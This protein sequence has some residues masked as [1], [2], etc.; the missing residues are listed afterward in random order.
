[1]TVFP[2]PDPGK[3]RAS[4]SRFL[5]IPTTR[6]IAPASEEESLKSVWRTLRK[7]KWWIS[8]WV[9]CGIGLAIVAC[10]VIPDQ[11][12]STATVQVGKDQTVQVDLSDN[13][14]P[15]LSESDTK[16]DIAT[17]MA[18]IKDNDT[19]LAVIKDL[20]LENHKPFKY[21]PSLM[22]WI[23]GGNRRIE[24]EKNLPL[25]QAPARRDRLLRMF[26][27]KLVVKNPADTRL[28]T[29]GF[30]NP[31]PNLSAK[32][33]NDV[34][35][36]YVK[37]ESEGQA[38]GVGI[39]LLSQE[40]SGLK[41][42]ME[43]DQK[44]LADYE[45]QTGLNHLLLRSI[46]EGNGGG[47]ITHIPA[48][49]KLDTLNQELTVAEANRIGKEAIYDLTKTHNSDVVAGLAHSSIPAIATSAVVTQGN[50]LNLLETL[51]QEQGR[52]RLEYSA[53][54]TK[55]GAKN[56]QMIELESQLSNV[57]KQISDELEQIDLRARNDYLV[58]LRNERGLQSEFQN[59]QKIAGQLN[60]SAVTLQML[61]QQ[62][63]SSRKLYDSLYQQIQ[64]A[65]IQAGL[66]A[67]NLRVTDVARPHPTPS[68]PNP[69]LYLAVGL[70]AGFL[71]GVSSAFVREH[72]DETVKTH[73]QVD[74]LTPLPV[75]ASIPKISGQ[76]QKALHSG[77]SI[78]AGGGGS[79]TSPLVTRPRSAAAEA[80]RALRTSIVLANAGLPL[81][82]LVVTSPLIG[83]GKTSVSYNLAV[84]F[85]QA[86][87][88]VLLI[89]AD[90]HH[91]RLHDYFGSSQTPGVGDVLSGTKTLESAIRAHP[92]IG[93]LSLLPAGN[94]PAL[95]G[96]LLASSKFDVMFQGL[97]Q[98]YSMI[99]MDTPPMLLVA[100]A[101]L[102]AGKAD[103]SLAVLRSDMTNR[104]AV[105]RMTETLERNGCRSIGLVLN[106]VD[107][108]SIDYYHAYGHRGGDRY[109]K[110]N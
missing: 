101:L 70:A 2:P 68:K 19:A 15:T 22:G 94:L 23:T 84:A 5:P 39:A 30:L 18:I 8:F 95:P 66:R 17:H 85:A 99:I 32:I 79:E 86:G 105:E 51:R 97:K 53:D 73:L 36:E 13:S 82:S 47:N 63:T 98:S 26:S 38:G 1:M 44:Q 93:N 25:S 107:T 78:V 96:E 55:Y 24:A 80:Y 48:L 88:R 103:A 12:Q 3:G 83:E 100:D 7:R 41:T 75:L 109:F 91:P 61:V 74:S 60:Q 59:Q 43:G 52:L 69:P 28:I 31:D 67:T 58:A 42:K 76:R 89:D 62:A 64:E 4:Q 27:K 21:H 20:N 11:Y 54:V 34:V 46:G 108:S 87:E 56:P 106:G 29:V 104:T 102:L 110:E 49:D 14:E 71:F 72:M 16:T 50:G 81:R 6:R 65:S 37:F 45:K 33:A 57:N 90:L 77:T 10:I 92:S 35:R 40:L 9:I